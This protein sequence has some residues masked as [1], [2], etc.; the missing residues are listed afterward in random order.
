M[1]TKHEEE[2]INRIIQYFSEKVL[3]YSVIVFTHG[4]RLPEGTTIQQFVD[5]NQKLKDVVRKCG[6][7]CH[8]F[9][10]RYWKNNNPEE[11]YR[12]NSYQLKELL[13]TVENLVISNNGGIYTDV[14]E[15]PQLT[16]KP[17]PEER[18]AEKHAGP[19]PRGPPRRARRGQESNT[20][21]PRDHE[22]T[23]KGRTPPQRHP[24]HPSNPLKAP[25]S[26]EP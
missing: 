25:R 22:S 10:N 13:I 21:Q 15:D 5:Q 18:V 11:K 17:T 3:K 1:F 14:G 2:V 16:H 20:K 19:Q 9:D 24:K 6:G 12:S 8:V 7:R 4:D 23:R 26:K